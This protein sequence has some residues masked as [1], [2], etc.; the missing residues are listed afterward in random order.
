ME[1]LQ[2]LIREVLNHHPDI[3]LCIIFGSIASGKA[4][5]DSD[6]D[7]AVAGELPLSAG[8]CL[9]LMDALSAATSR[10][11]DLVDL[12]AATGQILRQALC[13]GVIVQNRNKN[14]YAGLI[15]RM[16][17]NQADMMPLSDRTLRERRRRFLNG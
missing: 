9:E 6:L 14:L 16:L 2:E 15:S 10:E 5:S 3:K 4:S 12:M 17:F 11:I 1:R 7:I 13:S 8:K